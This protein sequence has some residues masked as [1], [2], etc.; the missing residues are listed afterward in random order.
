MK[1]GCIDYLNC[2]PFYYHM[3]SIEPLLGVE[4]VRARPNV[5][6]DMLRRGELDLSPVSAAVYPGLQGSVSLLPDFCLSSAGYVRSVVLNS[7][8]PIEELD[9][10][11]VG[12]TTASE[13]SVVLLKILLEKYFGIKPDYVPAAPYPALGEGYDAA[14]VIGNE[15]LWPAAEPVEYSYDLGDLWMRKTGHPV[16]F[17][18]F[19]LRSELM[20]SRRDEVLAVIRSYRKSIDMLKGHDKKLIQAAEAAYPRIQYSAEKYY[21][22]LRFE[23]DDAFREAL[24]FYYREASFLGL[25]SGVDSISWA[26]VDDDP[27]K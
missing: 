9:G 1:I 4:V 24:M 26:G 18:V 23:F 3:D 11:K 20:Q 2:Y 12:L 17:A 10:R 16:V 6:N 7:R 19:A 15:A 25:L 21:S 14:L 5:L 22:L 13:T 8:L 27:F